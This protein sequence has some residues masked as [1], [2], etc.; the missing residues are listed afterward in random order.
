MISVLMP[1][2]NN[3]KFLDASIKSILNQTYK[4]F[5]L[6]IINDGSTEPIEDI[7]NSYKDSRIKIFKNKKNIGL[8]KCL[9]RCLDISSGEYIARQDSD[10]ISKPTRFEEQLR[11]FIE[12]IGLVTTYAYAVNEKGKRIPNPYLDKSSRVNSGDIMKGNYLV[13]PSAIY[14]REVFKK[15]GYYDDNIYISQDYN[16]WIRLLKF[17]K[18][19]ILPKELYI[20]RKHSNSVRV[21]HTEYYGFDWAKKCKERAEKCPIIN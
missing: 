7:L 5:E 6:I 10:D 13:G 12:E 4:D 11:L 8:T 20:M 16:Y 19:K 1:V 14:S 3:Y 9:N 17:F 18:V 21:L 2:Y 15:I